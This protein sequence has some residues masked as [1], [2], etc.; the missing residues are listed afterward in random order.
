MGERRERGEREAER[1]RR[2]GGEKRSLAAVTDDD[3]PSK[4]KKKHLSLLIA[5]THPQNG[6][7]IVRGHHRLDDRARRGRALVLIA[8]AESGSSRRAREREAH[9]TVNEIFLFAVGS[10]SL[11]SQRRRFFC[12]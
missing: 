7:V 12:L 11:S 3:V 9:R 2:R 6:R 5:P 8:A 1:E 4:L 10:L